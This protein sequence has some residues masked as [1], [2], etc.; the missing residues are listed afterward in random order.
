MTDYKNGPCYHIQNIMFEMK[1]KGIKIV[2]RHDCCYPL[3]LCEKCGKAD[4]DTELLVD[5]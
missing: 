2:N 5:D 1:M 4:I 3:L